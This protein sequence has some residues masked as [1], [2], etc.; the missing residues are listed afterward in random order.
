MIEQSG[1]ELF[2]TGRCLCGA[3]SYQVEDSLRGV[4]NCHCS[5]CRRFH[6]H[7]A[8]YTAAPRSEVKI[9]DTD[10]QLTWY[11]SSSRARRGFCGRCGSSLFWDE[12]DAEL[13]RI[14]AGTLDQPTGLKTTTH[15]YIA[16]QGDYYVLA[17]ELEKRP[18]GLRG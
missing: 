8:A 17:D 6:G 10:Q 12:H 18:L 3:I 7:F 15:I 5:Q 14:T 16:H 1:P 13:L 11:A 9:K 2:N 4:V